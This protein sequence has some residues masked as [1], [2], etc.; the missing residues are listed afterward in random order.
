MKRKRWTTEE[1]IFILENLNKLTAAE[2]IEKLGVRKRQFEGMKYI[3]INKY[4]GGL[5]GITDDKIKRAIEALKLEAREEKEKI[6]EMERQA[7]F[8]KKHHEH[9]SIPEMA[10]KLNATYDTIYKRRE[11]LIENN[12]I[13]GS[14]IKRDKKHKCD[15]NWDK[16]I[17]KI[18]KNSKREKTEIEKKI[19]A[20]DRKM[21]LGRNYRIRKL[22]ERD[23]FATMD[24]TG[25]LVQI[26]DKF[27]TFKS[28]CRTESYLKIDFIIGYYAIEGARKCDHLA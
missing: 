15:G 10:K 7:E 22:M 23:K 21:K 4:C 6:K 16:P 14:K 11:H 8:I 18:I 12:I 1:K 25:K 5:E 26:T 24:F 20:Q 13:D 9:M 3:L 19:E 27:Y 2:F 28:R 17:K